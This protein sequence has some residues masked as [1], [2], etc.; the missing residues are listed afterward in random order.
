MTILRYLEHERYDVTEDEIVVRM[1]A[2]G[3][4]GTWWAD[5]RQTRGQTMREKRKLFQQFVQQA[6]K[7]GMHPCQVKI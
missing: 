1:M 3:E 5:T 6:V 7:R 4:K 2:T